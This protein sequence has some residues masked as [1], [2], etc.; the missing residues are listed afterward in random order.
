MSETTMVGLGDWLI[1]HNACDVGMSLL[2]PALR[3]FIHEPGKPDTICQLEA[4]VMRCLH[5]L[6]QRGDL[7]EL[8]LDVK[9]ECDAAG[10]VKL[11]ALVDGLTYSAMAQRFGYIR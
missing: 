11:F 10:K 9:A 7:R 3:S 2:G 5:E 1:Y 4:T 8:P 6:Q